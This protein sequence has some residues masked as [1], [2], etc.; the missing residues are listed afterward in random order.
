MPKPIAWAGVIA[1]LALILE[2][3]MPGLKQP[4]LITVILFVAGT[5]LWGGAIYFWLQPAEAQSPSSAGGP[6]GSN[7]PPTIIEGSPGGGIGADVTVQGTPGATTPNVG[8]IAPNGMDIR[9]NGGVGLRLGVGGGNGPAIGAISG[10]IRI[11]PG[12]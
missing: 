3:L 7:G 4:P 6:P 10:P 12:H 1:G 2:A 9:S 8:L 11:S 5:L